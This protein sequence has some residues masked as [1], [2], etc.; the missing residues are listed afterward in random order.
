M[1]TG[2]QQSTAH[3]GAT[4]VRNTRTLITD[5]LDALGCGLSLR[6]W[7]QERA[8]QAK[9]VRQR[10][11]ELL[12]AS[13]TDAQTALTSQLYASISFRSDDPRFTPTSSTCIHDARY[14]TAQSHSPAELSKLPPQTPLF[15]DTLP[16]LNGAKLSSCIIYLCKGHAPPPGST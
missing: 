5:V 16:V 6:H 10:L 4:Q 2:R 1:F 9:K 11:N 7:Q 8:V 14:R 15:T 3:G 13:E 12:Q